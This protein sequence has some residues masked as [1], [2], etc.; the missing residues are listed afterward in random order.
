[1]LIS[2]IINFFLYSMLNSKENTI[3]NF[4]IYWKDMPIYFNTII[5][6]A[7][8]NYI[9][10]KKKQIDLIKYKESVVFPYI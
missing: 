10:F 3:Q 9:K 2:H 6:R 4:M 7:I 5:S 1:M 8:L